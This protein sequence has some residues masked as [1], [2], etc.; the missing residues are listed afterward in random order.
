LKSIFNSLVIQTNNNLAKN[1]KL[2]S[3]KYGNFYAFLLKKSN[4]DK[5]LTKLEVLTQSIK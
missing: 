5:E 4:V 1:A 3:A 2:K